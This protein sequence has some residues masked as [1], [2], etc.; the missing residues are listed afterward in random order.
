MSAET[1]VPE[2]IDDRPVQPVT[3][4]DPLAIIEKRNNLLERLLSYG[5]AATHGGHWFDQGGKPYLGAAG[6]EAV[7]RRCAVSVKETRKVKTLSNDDKGD[8][9]IYEYTGRFSLPGGND[10]IEALG[11]CS[12]RDVFL[13]TETKAG[14]EVSEID[15]G[16]IMKAAYSNMIVNGVTRLLGIRGMTWERLDELG[17]KRGDTQKV[18]YSAGAKGGGASGEFTVKFGNC[19][20]HP[21]ST[22]SDA[23]LNWYGDAFRRDIADPAKAQ[24]QANAKKQLAAVEAE[25]SR[26][27]NAAAT[28]ANAPAGKTPWAQIQELATKFQ[29]SAERIGGI[30]KA[31]TGKTSTGA[32][33]Q[34]DVGKCEAAFNP[35]ASDEPL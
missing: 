2:I 18:E 3:M 6:A 22:W 31:A 28:P 29:V 33:T 4:V 5:I 7:A 9:Y 16:S 13:G 17:I 26:R 14:R 11:T 30:V 34:E 20:G 25:M 23:D 24:Y 21:I 27:K 35:P 10:E 15:E 12:S 8:F 32:L 19:K 1:F